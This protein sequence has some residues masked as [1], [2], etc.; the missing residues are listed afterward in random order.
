M[1]D[2]CPR[3]KNNVSIGNIPLSL[4]NL[5]MNI[6]FYFNCSSQPSVV[7]GVVPIKCL[8]NG[9]GKKSYVFEVGKDIVQKSWTK[10]C[11][12][13]VTVAV[14]HDQIKSGDL[15]NEFGVAMSKGFVLDWNRAV[16]CDECELSDGF[17]LGLAVTAAG[18]C[19][20]RLKK[21]ILGNTSKEDN[22]DIETFLKNHGVL[23]IK[24]YKFFDVKK[25]TD[26]FKV[27]LGQG[28]FGVVYKEKLSDGSNMAVKMLNPFK[29]NGKKFIN[30]ISDFGLAKLCPGKE[31]L[32]SMSDAGGTIGYIA[33]EV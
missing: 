21:V 17:A 30:E 9:Q 4:S 28:D 23:T 32:I 5:D 18:N 27:K 25:L 33:P 26:S 7:G 6:T 10:S 24:G 3:A 31:S 8:I 13:E 16:D 29:E 14:K 12:A 20:T 19:W 11:D 15:I 1:N 22:Q 2:P